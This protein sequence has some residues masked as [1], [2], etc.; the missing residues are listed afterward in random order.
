MSTNQ[1]IIEFNQLYDTIKN[2]ITTVIYIG[3][4]EFKHTILL[5]KDCKFLDNDSR[6]E[7]DIL[8]DLNSSENLPKVA[9]L[10]V[11]SNVLMYISNAYS[12][13]NKM[14]YVA[15]KYVILQE[16]VIRLRTEVNNKY[17]DINRFYCSKFIPNNFDCL[18]NAENQYQKNLINIQRNSLVWSKYY[19]SPSP[20]LPVGT[21][22]GLWLYQK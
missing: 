6:F 22:E 21:L 10:I 8:H 16:P 14:I 18:K 1:D 15:N 19:H 4:R 11:C 5:E 17:E 13:L 9:D 7:P 12:A 20:T 2:N 3:C